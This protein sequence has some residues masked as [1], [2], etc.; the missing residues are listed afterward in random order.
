[1]AGI[2]ELTTS[3]KWTQYLDVQS[4]FYSYSPSNSILILMQNPNATRVAGYKTW[5]GLEHQVM[6]K[7]SALRILAPMRYMSDDISEGEKTSEIR[8]FKLVPVFDI[9]QTEGPD[10]PDVVSKLSGVAPEGVFATLTEF[11]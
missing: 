8:G 1:E 5:E 2:A 4:R 10:L 11:A 9:S 3:E 6:A 7:E